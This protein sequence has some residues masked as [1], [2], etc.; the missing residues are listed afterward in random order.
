MLR[1]NWF[2]KCLFERDIEFDFQPDNLDVWKKCYFYF[3]GCSREE[4]IGRYI[5]HPEYDEKQDLYYFPSDREKSSGSLLGRTFD[6]SE[7]RKRVTIAQKY[8]RPE[9]PPNP[10]IYGAL[11]SSQ[12]SKLLIKALMGPGFSLENPFI[13]HNKFDIIHEKKFIPFAFSFCLPK[14]VTYAMDQFGRSF[15]FIYLKKRGFSINKIISLQQL[16]PNKGDWWLYCYGHLGIFNFRYPDSRC[17][18]CGA[19]ITD[20]KIVDLVTFEKI[21]SLMEGQELAGWNYSREVFY[22]LA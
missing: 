10:L 8:P 17:Y 2:W 18:S 13:L 19:L 3:F 22:S 12:M 20:G 6:S 4:M 14:I 5:E 1:D 7:I 21:K 16:D 9:A 11:T 15:V